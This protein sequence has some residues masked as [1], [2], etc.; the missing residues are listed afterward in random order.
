MVI[1]GLNS[2]GAWFLLTLPLPFVN[3]ENQSVN[4]GMEPWVN[5]ETEEDLANK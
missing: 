4:S 1:S 5:K 2:S 3:G